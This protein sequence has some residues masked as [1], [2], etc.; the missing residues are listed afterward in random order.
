MVSDGVDQVETVYYVKDLTNVAFTISVMCL[1][2][3]VLLIL[4]LLQSKRRPLI[5]MSLIKKIRNV[6]IKVRFSNIIQSY[7]NIAYLVISA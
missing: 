2:A 1:V 7:L 3:S 6:S 5:R 4:A